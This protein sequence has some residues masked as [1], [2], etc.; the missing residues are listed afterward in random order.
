MAVY[1]IV[2]QA[3]VQPEILQ[4]AG[5]VLEMGIYCQLIYGL[6]IARLQMDDARIIAELHNL[7]LG[8]VMGA[9]IDIYSVPT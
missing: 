3:I 2:L 6:D 1:Q 4:R 9:G 8:G 5:E 7:R